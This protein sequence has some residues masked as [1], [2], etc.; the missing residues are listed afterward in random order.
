M[1][2]QR[3]ETVL[4]HPKASDFEQGDYEKQHIRLLKKFAFQMLDMNCDKMLCETDLF[5]FLELHREDSFFKTALIYDLQDIVAAFKVR[6]QE[7][8]KQ[9]ETF[10]FKD[11]SA[12][13]M[14][15]LEKYLAGAAKRADD[16]K[17]ILN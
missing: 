17:E 3:L 12:P 8:Q 10:D 7:L 6:N 14:K 13:K 5:T 1:F 15:D 11:E 16:R 2:Y 9:D 4:V